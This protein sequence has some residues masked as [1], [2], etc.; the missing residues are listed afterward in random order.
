MKGKFIIF[1][2]FL[3]A[4]IF[5]QDK[6]KEVSIGLN[7]TAAIFQIIDET[8]KQICLFYN[9]KK[10][11]LAVRFD[12]DF[13]IIDSLHGNKPESKYDDLIGYSKKGN[14]YFSYWAD[15][16]CKEIA[17]MSFDFDKKSTAITTKTIDLEKEKVVHKTT[18]NNIFYII[19]TVKSSN[20]INIYC[21]EDGTFTKKSIDIYYKKFIDRENKQITLWDLF[22]EGSYIDPSFAVQNISTDSPASLA[23]TAS[24]KKVY[25]VNNTLLFTFDY[26]NNFT[27]T[28]Q[29]DLDKFSITQRNFFKPYFEEK[30]LEDGSQFVTYDDSNSFYINESF[31]ILKGNSDRM[32]LTFKDLTDN[33]IKKYWL[34]SDKELEI[35]NSD[36]IQ[37]NG[38]I[39]NTRILDKSSQLLRKISNLNP[40]I[41]CY[42]DLGGNIILTI[43][44]VSENQK[45]NA[46]TYGALIGGF[47]GSLIG[48]AISSN[49][50]MNNINSY[51]D[52][53]VVYIN[54]L[55]DASFNH[56][57]SPLN[58]LAFDK[59][60][61]FDEE[62]KSMKIKTVFKYKS[63]LYF[64]GYNIESG[65]YSFYK[66]TD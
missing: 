19:S 27:Q 37:E 6:V 41:S 59:V 45:N 63:N 25:T 12:E 28:I 60:R 35:K 46:M 8:N 43:G 20:I 1:L 10:T 66:F 47:A 38:S 24:K 33:E 17:T 42:K 34:F 52:R 56:I 30:T 2:I 49:Y 64:G 44:G 14:T 4:N 7:K 53:K 31:A 36:I 57:N 3:T 21:F 55:F 15:S 11:A 32:V 18:I 29:I 9:D 51:K 5:S 62:N 61:L 23:F 26:N 65:K 22:R 13:N 39:S 16:K 58:K 40:S 54:C 48:A 50:T